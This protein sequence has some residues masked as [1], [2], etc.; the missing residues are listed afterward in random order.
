MVVKKSEVKNIQHTDNAEKR[1]TGAYEERIKK[2]VKKM[3]KTINN[4]E[5]DMQ[6]EMASMG[7]GKKRGKSMKS[8]GSP[9]R[10]KSKTK[11]R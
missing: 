4:L 5:A 7:P 3:N 10:K 11:R 1:L 6:D 9:A 8:D 2:A